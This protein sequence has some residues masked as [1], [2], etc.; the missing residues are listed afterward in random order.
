MEDRAISL[1]WKEKSNGDLYDARHPATVYQ[2]GTLGWDRKLDNFLDRLSGWNLVPASKLATGHP[3]HVVANADFVA[4]M[5][6]LSTVEALE[7]IRRGLSAE[8][9]GP[10]KESSAVLFI[11]GMLRSF[12]REVGPVDIR[13]A[14]S[15]LAVYVAARCQLA[16]AG[17]V[18]GVQ[19]KKL[20][21]GMP[22][23][24]NPQGAVFA[25]P[26]QTP[27]SFDECRFQIINGPEAGVTLGI[28]A[29]NTDVWEGCACG[30]E[31]QAA[32]GNLLWVTIR[33][34][35]FL[36]TVEHAVTAL[37]D[38]VRN[39]PSGVRANFLSMFDL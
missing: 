28:R 39:D 27:A 16:H 6:M 14:R 7:G 17:I 20:S 4:V 38:D 13:H 33:P 30:V 3:D 18:N 19:G 22:H 32:A 8:G 12:Y 34:V 26:N 11:D 29:A 37:A 35:E 1:N 9:V 31:V 23:Q 5:A 2:S 25:W 10:Q 15:N 36:R 21:R 24:V